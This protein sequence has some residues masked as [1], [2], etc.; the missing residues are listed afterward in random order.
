MRI[1][2][3]IALLL[4]YSSVSSQNIVS[5]RVLGSTSVAQL[6]VLLLLTGSDVRAEY[7]VR[8]ISVTYTTTGTKGEKENASGLF[9]VPE[10]IST[11]LPIHCHLHGTTSGRNAVPSQL[12]GGYEIALVYASLGQFVVMPDYLGMGESQG[13]HPYVH[14]ATE[15]NAA[16][17]MIYA[18]KEYAESTESVTLSNQLIIAGYSQGGHAAMALQG[19][20]ETSYSDDFDLIACTPMSGPYDL[21]GVFKEFIL[22]ESEYFF[23]GYV[24][25]QLIGYQEVYGDIYTSLD[26]VLK[27]PYQAHANQLAETGDLGNLNS[28]LS[29]LLIANEGRSIPLRMFED[30]FVQDFQ[31][32]RESPLNIALDEN[33]TYNFTAQTPTRIIYCQA[34]D[35]VPYQNAIIADEQLNANGS[36]NVSSIDVLSTG[37]HGTCLIPAVEES[38]RF[39]NQFL[40]ISSNEELDPINGQINVFPNP[41]SNLLSIEIEDRDLNLQKMRIFS[42]EGALVATWFDLT[43]QNAQLDISSLVNGLYAIE[44]TTEKGTIWRKVLKQ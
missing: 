22:G 11:A 44:I 19:E 3:I 25:Y 1:H 9:I 43:G 12:S 7:G 26:A 15:A 14:A 5:T 21:S 27:P 23:P 36:A 2:T 40:V 10:N 8:L 16:V 28:E 34:D 41:A 38:I 4:F 33:V 31:S 18:A 32:N 30:E 13:F 24:L 17:D 35:Q 20:I 39:I 37:N 6:N 42:V 29:G